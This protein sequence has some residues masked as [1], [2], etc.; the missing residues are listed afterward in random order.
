MA[1]VSPFKLYL[2]GPF[3]LAHPEAADLETPRRKTR[4]LLA[5]LAVA[6]QLHTRQAL[7]DLFCQDAQSPARALSL[8]FTRMRQRLGTDVLITDN[9]TVQFNAQSAWVDFAIFQQQLSGDLSPKSAADLQTAVALYRGEFLEGL[10]LPDAPEFELWLLGQRAQARH[11]LER[12]LLALVQ[13]LSQDGQ[14]DTAVV[15]ARQLLQHN[16]LLEEA[17]AQLIWLYAQTGQRDA[18]L[19]QYEQCRGLLQN[20]LGVEPTDSLQQLQTAILSGELARPFHLQQTPSSA[21]P[22]AASDFVGRTAEYAQLQAAWRSAQAGQGSAIVIGAAAGGG[23][24]RL[25]AELTRHVPPTA[26]YTGHC[27]EST[28][29][30]PY[31]PWLE[32][33]EAHWQRLDEAA[34]QQFPPATLA[35]VSRLLPGLARR[36]PA[37]SVV[38]DEPERLFTAVADFL[39]QAPSV[40]RDPKTVNRKATDNGLPITDTPCIL[41]LDDLQW[42]DEASL[43]LL[44]YLSQRVGRFPWLLIGAHRT[45][46][47]ADA[48]ALSMLL[49]DFARRGLPHLTLTPLTAAEIETLAAHAWPQ[50]APGYRG[51]V[52]AMLAQATGGNALFVTA[53]LQELAASDHLPAELPVPATVQDLIQRRLRRLSQDSRQ[54]LEALAVWG[55][56]ASVAQL[57]QISARSEEETVQAL[58][59]GLQWGLILV[60]M[61]A[62]SAVETPALRADAAS[63]VEVAVLPTSYQFHHDLVREA[64]YATLSAVRRQRLHR[65]AAQWLTRIAQRQPEPIRQEMAAR[66]LYHAQR[67]EAFDLAFQWAPLAAA[68]AR[69][70]FAYRDALHALDAMRSAFAQCQ[71]WPDFDLDTAE[72]ALFEQLIWWLSHSWFLG[73]SEVEERAVRQQAQALL[74][75]HPSPLRAAQLDLV[76]AQMT[77]DYAEAIPVMQAVYRQ[78]RQLGEL[79]LAALA[80]LSAANASI[81]LSRNKDGRSLYEQ[82]LTLYRQADDVAG[83]VKCL[84]GLAWTAINLGEIAVAL[85]YSEQALSISQSQG[86]K[87]GEAQALFGLAAAWNFYY[88]PDRVAALAEAAQALYVQVGFQGRAVRPSLYLGAAEH[89]RGRWQE[90]LTIYEAVL[91]QAIAFEDSWTTGWAAQLAGRIYLRWGQLD[92]AAKRLQQAQ[93]LRLKSGERQ[94]Q[95]SDLAWLGRLALAQGDVTAALQQTAQA[96]TLLNAFHGE[97]Y[98][99]E[100]PDVLMCR[101]EALAAAGE[102]AQAMGIARRAQATLRQFAQR[103]D[104]ADRLARFM[105]HPSNA[106]VETAVATQQ[107]PR[108]P[109]Q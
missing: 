88:V 100:Q 29:T 66:V 36:L 78:F 74:A 26:V 16:P 49:D 23:K 72:P 77:L 64:V 84:A 32:I 109:D 104:G 10:T 57:Q 103:I 45:D 19:R 76:T 12:G 39:A 2:L 40:N 93:Q 43:H 21:V 42:A 59:R 53:V 51:H 5:Y 65:R 94:N 28:R 25:I 9:N 90:A 11:L 30:L 4:A 101:A 61:P 91:A 67:G 37:A 18:A 99:W 7:M 68:H 92:V 34:W 96:I 102:K 98:V 27:Y 69:Q 52:A 106:R 89:A 95:V 79:S 17:H 107:I 85:R 75:R 82:A 14:Y 83:E 47:A 33:L 8:L 38:A 54:V 31:Q 35:Y 44:H 48:P 63:L 97:F 60:N 70:M 6:H 41:F 81:T 50:L 73:K 108:W 86:D 56:R 3:Q 71:F 13:R 62:L 15:H 55:R 24:T 20:E 80:L 46:E 58:E 1:A 105:A 87:L 22:P